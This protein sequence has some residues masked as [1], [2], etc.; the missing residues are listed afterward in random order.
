[1]FVSFGKMKTSKHTLYHSY[2]FILN[3]QFRRKQMLWVVRLF[4]DCYLLSL[5]K[6]FLSSHLCFLWLR[7]ADVDHQHLCIVHNYTDQWKHFLKAASRL[8][9]RQCFPSRMLPQQSFSHVFCVSAA[10]VFVTSQVHLR[11]T[12]WI[13]LFPTAM[14]GD[15]VHVIMWKS[16]FTV[17]LFV[18]LVLSPLSRELLIPWIFP[19]LFGALRGEMSI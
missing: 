6:H 19:S 15:D 1:M 5:Y 18:L 9:F 13:Q 12:V 4:H 10:S 7:S 17:L 14:G 11:T 16:I 2:F 8:T 3:V